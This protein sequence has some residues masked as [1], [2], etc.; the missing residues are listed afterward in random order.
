MASVADSEVARSL[1]R[2][3]RL[4]HPTRGAIRFQTDPAGTQW[5]LCDTSMPDTAASFTRVIGSLATDSKEA[6]CSG[7]A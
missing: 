7:L 6:A 2:L 5:H 4:S 1:A 3:V